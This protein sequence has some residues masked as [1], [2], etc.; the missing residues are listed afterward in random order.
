MNIRTERRGLGRGLG[1][2]FQRTEPQPMP[3]SSNGDAQAATLAGVPDG[4]YFTELPLDSISPNPRQPRSVFD[5]EAMNELVESIREVGMLQPIVVR[6]MGGAKFE[7][8][9]GERRWRAAQQA[10]VETIPAIVRETADHQLLRDALLENLH[11]AQLNPLEEAAA[12][13]QMLEDFGCTQEE[14]AT[15]IKRS[16]P[17]I[18]N[19]IRLLRLPPTVQ[20]RIAAG[21]I[22]AGHARAL[23]AM[24]DPATQERLA[25]RIV[26]EGLSVR[27]VEELVTVG[28]PE[29]RAPRRTRRPRL[30]APK[31]KDLADRLSDH[32][33]TR[34]RVD[35]GRT[36]GKIVIEFATV[37]DLERIVALIE[38]PAD[39][40]EQYRQSDIQEEVEGV[41]AGS[42]AW[43]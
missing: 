35:L 8:V 36:K 21:V 31:V 16:R 28:E 13:Q 20:R 10:G 38:R 19:T 40:G 25:Q 5:E 1:E 3:A 4:S 12:Y 26:A 37:D 29:E 18:S 23:L 17:Q 22:S 24:E 9:M 14:L 2:L 34:V 6:P 33:E 42:A 15:R 43:A 41:A 30:V 39:A 7:L 11:R 27:A 32:F